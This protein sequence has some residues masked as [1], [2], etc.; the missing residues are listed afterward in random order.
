LLLRKKKLFHILNHNLIIQLYKYIHRDK[1]IEKS[2]TN[3]AIKLVSTRSNDRNYR[4]THRTAITNSVCA[5]VLNLDNKKI[6]KNREIIIYPK[7]TRDAPRNKKELEGSKYTIISELH[8]LY[9]AFFYVLLFPKCSPTYSLEEYKN[10]SATSNEKLTTASYYKYIFMPRDN[11]MARLRLMRRLSQQY[12]VDMYLKIESEKLAFQH[13]YK[14]QKKMRLAFSSGNTD[15]LV[16]NQDTNKVGKRIVLSSDFIGG[17][18]HLW[19]E[20]LEGMTI[21]ANTGIVYY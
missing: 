21:V 16:A 14:H 1:H 10:K 18:R 12:I 5:I 19:R 6:D 20:Y 4:Q 17:P 7:N 3:V 13:S 2:S 9:D 8:P 15:S 11:N